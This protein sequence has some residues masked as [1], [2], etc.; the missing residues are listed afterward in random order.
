MTLI[1]GCG[2]ILLKPVTKKK[3]VGKRFE[4]LKTSD[5]VKLRK[6]S[7]LFLSREMCPCK[8]SSLDYQLD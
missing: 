3:N 4:I 5:S 7:K 1:A 8:L 2:H 6:L